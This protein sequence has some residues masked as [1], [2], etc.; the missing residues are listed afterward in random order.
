ML[1][2]LFVYFLV[3]YLE[4]VCLSGR[5]ARFGYSGRGHNN[6]KDAFYLF[7]AHRLSLF[8]VIHLFLATIN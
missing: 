5:E 2:P 8:C 1:I 4:T 6:I 3:V 7:P